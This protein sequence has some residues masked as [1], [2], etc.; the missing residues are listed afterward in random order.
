[1]KYDIESRG[2]SPETKATI[3]ESDTIKIKIG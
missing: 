3:I 1:M 2:K